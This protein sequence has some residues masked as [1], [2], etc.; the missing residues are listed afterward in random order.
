MESRFDLPTELTIYSA[1]DTRAALLAWVE[2]ERV[3]ATAA[4]Q[5]CACEVA[6]IDAAGLQLLVGLDKMDL[7]WTLTNPSSVF[8]EACQTLGLQKWL[9]NATASE[10]SHA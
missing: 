4:L 10:E 2:K 9:T 3:Q 5:V 1:T 7:I 8:T 6:Q